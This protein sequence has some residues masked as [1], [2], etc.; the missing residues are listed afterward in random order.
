M[1]SKKTQLSKDESPGSGIQCENHQEDL[2]FKR[3]HVR[4]LTGQNVS[5]CFSHEGS[6][7][8]SGY[9]EVQFSLLKT[10]VRKMGLGRLTHNSVSELYLKLVRYSKSSCRASRSSYLCN[11]KK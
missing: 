2:Y 5:E 9:K 7:P 11:P 6:M 10:L 4:T 1:Q 8:P 3:N